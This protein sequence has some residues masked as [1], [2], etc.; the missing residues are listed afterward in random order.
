ML[1]AFTSQFWPNTIDGLAIGAIYALI[2][3]GYTMV[4][5]VMRLIN[6]AHGEIFMIGTFASLAVLNAFGLS[7]PLAGFA[8]VGVFV[9]CLAASMAASGGAAVVLEFVA[10][11][12]LRKRGSPRIAA[13]IAAIGASLFLQELFAQVVVPKLYSPGHGR[14]FIGTPR[15]MNKETLFYVNFDFHHLLY[16]G[17]NPHTFSDFLPGP[18]RNDKL[19]VIVAAILMMVLLDFFVN[20]TKIGRGIRAT[21]MDPQTATLMGVNINQIV[22]LTF[23]VGGVMAGAA[24]LLYVL[25][26]EVTKYSIGVIL[27]IKAFTAAVMGGIGN[28]RGALIGGFILGLIENWGASLTGSEWKDVIAFSILV[29]ILLLR[30]TGILGES[31]QQARA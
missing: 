24:G 29:L 25:V 17:P 2:A 8:L 9:L 16:V 11:R 21:S 22:M 23:L 15:L 5:G 27:G 19:L 30:P 7:S 18:V 10:Y 12:P 6:F 3:L 4:Y 1:Q 14:D 31:L 28:L 20:R 26:F 13:L